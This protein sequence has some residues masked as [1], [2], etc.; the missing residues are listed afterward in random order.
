[1]IAY[2]NNNNNATVILCFK[3]WT[4]GQTDSLLLL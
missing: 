2:D 4:S 3:K 1:M